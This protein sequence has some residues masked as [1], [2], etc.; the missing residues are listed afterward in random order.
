MIVNKNLSSF[1]FILLLFLITSSYAGPAGN[2]IFEDKIENTTSELGI[3]PY[4]LIE[5][6]EAEDGITINYEECI[7]RNKDKKYSKT[8]SAENINKTHN[9]GLSIRINHDD[10]FGGWVERHGFRFAG[11][12]DSEMTEYVFESYSNYGG[13]GWFSHLS[14]Y[15]L[16]DNEL[17]F[18]GTIGGGDRCNDGYSEFLFTEYNQVI[19][20]RAATAF[21]LLNTTDRTDHRTERLVN[22]F[23]DNVETKA[24]HFFHQLRPYDDI[25]NSAAGCYGFVVYSTGA[26]QESVKG[27]LL[28]KSSINRS[29]NDSVNAC[30]NNWLSSLNLNQFTSLS[31]NENYFYLSKDDWELALYS[32]KDQCP[33]GPESHHQRILDLENKER[34]RTKLIESKNIQLG[35]VTVFSKQKERF[36]GVVDVNLSG[37][38]DLSGYSFELA[39]KE[40]F[41]DLELEWFAVHDGIR[42]EAS[43]INDEKYQLYITTD[44]EVSQSYID[45][46]ILIKDEN[47]NIDLAKK[48]T[49]LIDPL[50]T[51][52]RDSVSITDCA[53]DVHS[54]RI[55]YP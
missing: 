45:L 36:E 41:E 5:A 20:A 26:E 44:D 50:M 30:F 35:D 24:N 27:V 2:F 23:N 49:V 18:L 25:D 29:Y 11:Y 40:Q 31:Q 12:I 16:S 54:C 22:A 48:Y 3:N 4:C 37:I 53:L 15:R 8:L 28:E 52:K 7:H 19:H 43:I 32:F 6:R 38:S 9:L 1:V 39:S 13:S 34:N 17:E 42:L 10:E 51:V 47:N 14:F 55:L 21:K 33:S 46:F